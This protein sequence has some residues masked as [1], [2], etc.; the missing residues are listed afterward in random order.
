MFG[1]SDIK[2]KGPLSLLSFIKKLG[3]VQ[4]FGTPCTVLLG[5]FQSGARMSRT[6]RDNNH[7]SEKCHSTATE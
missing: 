3:H 4:E 1:A 6:F 7:N 5:T 2:V